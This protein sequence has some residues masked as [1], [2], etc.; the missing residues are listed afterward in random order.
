V[1]CLFC[2]WD[3]V[4]VGFDLEDCLVFIELCGDP[5]GFAEAVFH[6]CAHTVGACTASC[7]V[8]SEDVVW[9][10][11]YRESVLFWDAFFH[12]PVARVPCGF[13]GVM[14]DLQGFFDF[15]FDDVSVVALSVAHD[16]SYDL[17]VWYGSDVA[18]ALVFG[19]SRVRS[20]E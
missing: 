15:E 6:T 2:E 11:A 5:D 8:V 10:R 3:V 1:K 20:V 7:W 9:V 4:F 19:F 18:L 17:V 14:S 13:D 16:E 12:E